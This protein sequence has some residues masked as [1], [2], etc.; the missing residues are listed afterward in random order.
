MGEGRRIECLFVGRV[1][2]SWVSDKICPPIVNKARGIPD[3]C[4]IDSGIGERQRRPRVRRQIYVCLPTAKD[5]GAD[6]FVQVRLAFPKWQFLDA[7]TVDDVGKA[8][9]G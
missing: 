4:R 1:A 9:S 3:V 8:V 6:A 5:G 7:P 2:D